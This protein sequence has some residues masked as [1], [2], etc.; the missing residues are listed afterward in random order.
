MLLSHNY[1]FTLNSVSHPWSVMKINMM[2]KNS[3]TSCTTFGS[4]VPSSTWT[5]QSSQSRPN[6][7]TGGP[8]AVWEYNWRRITQH[9]KT[10]TA[11]LWQILTLFIFLSDT[12]VNPNRKWKLKWSEVL[13]IQLSVNHEIEFQ[14]CFWTTLE[15]C[16]EISKLGFFS[17]LKCTIKNTKSSTCE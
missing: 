8:K 9:V 11:W 14:T 13:H 4:L 5:G 15:N 17:S 2:W 3:D 10:I 6:S 1:F 16:I 12:L 7:Q